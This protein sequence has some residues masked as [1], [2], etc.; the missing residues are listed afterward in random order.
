MATFSGIS[1]EER[2]R[3]GG[4]FFPVHGVRLRYAI[5]P[6]PGGPAVFLQL[7]GYDATPLDIPA[8][9]TA[10]QLAALRAKV[11]TSASL[12]YAGGVITATLANVSEPQE[13]KKTN[14]LYFVTLNFLIPW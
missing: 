4:A 8:R 1:W 2:G 11:S 9:V 5:L 3:G 10:A 13:I 12:D 7:L 6:A 14:D